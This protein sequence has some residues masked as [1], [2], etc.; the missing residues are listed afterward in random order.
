MSTPLSNIPDGFEL[1]PESIP[2]APE[3]YEV[4]I[5][6]PN[7]AVINMG[8]GQEAAQDPAMAQYIESIGPGQAALIATGK[9]MTTMGRAAEQLYNVFSGDDASFEETKAR[10]LQEKAQFQ[11]LEERYPKS[12]FVGEVAGETAAMP[13][14]GLGSGA[15]I[16]YFS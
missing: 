4:V 2:P 10:A 6:T 7:Q 11:P 5:P 1:S 9:G 13:F 16:C 14:G 12:T 15:L 8:Q 3:G